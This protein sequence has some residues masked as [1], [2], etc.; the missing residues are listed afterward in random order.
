MRPVG[1]SALTLR[2]ELDTGLTDVGCPPQ[3]LA[4]SVHPQTSAEEHLVLDLTPA[5]APKH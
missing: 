4:C 1:L 5:K 3:D 2:R